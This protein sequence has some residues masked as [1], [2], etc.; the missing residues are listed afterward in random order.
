LSI[1][2]SS[3]ALQFCGVPF[4][5]PLVLASGVLGVSSS[6]LGFVATHGAGAVTTKSCS[7]L[8]RPGHPTPVVAIVEGPVGE[9]G[10]RRPIGLL[11]AVGLS[12]PG[13]VAMAAEIRAYRERFQVPVIASVFG[14]HPGEF[15]EVTAILA[16]AAPDL[17]EVNVSCP[18]VSAEFGEPFAAD[19]VA[20][21]AITRRVK[22]A[23]RGIP[24]AV[25]ISIHCPSLAVMAK[26]CAD[27]GA[28]AITA[29]NT[30]GP[31]LHIDVHHERPVLS[32]VTG[33]L[34]GPAV[35]PLAVRAVWEIRKAVSL[36]ILGT[37]GVADADGALQ[38]ILAGA[39]A[40]GVGTAF[41]LR[42]E[43][44][45]IEIAEG[46]DRHLAETGRSSISELVGAAHA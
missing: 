20:T 33:G 2:A 9:R 39:S 17:F 34:S 3:L 8:P 14:A 4:A 12:N 28:D 22:D 45:L 29:I 13:A 16:E 5:N 32:N 24:V 38:L 46:L 44:V 31:G 43:N 11:N 21:A 37:G 36:P 40:I 18:N 7:L 27:A 42:G 6:S 19:P 23:S 1:G 30:V 26:S 41:W 25:K 35:L 15:A 10:E